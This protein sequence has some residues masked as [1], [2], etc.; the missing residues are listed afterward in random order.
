[1]TGQ[2]TQPSWFQLLIFGLK[3]GLLS[4]GGPVGQIALLRKELVEQKR[5]MS[6]AEFD[7]GLDFC[8]LLPGPE[9]QQLASFCG[10]KIGRGLVGGLIIGTTFILPG[11]LIMFLL[12][13]LRATNGDVAWIKAGFLG[14]AAAVVAIVIAALYRLVRQRLTKPIPI[15]LGIVGL[16]FTLGGW[17]GFA[18]LVITAGL[19][20]AF[21]LR[22]KLVPAIAIP[23]PKFQRIVAGIGFL[24]LSVASMVGLA[25]FLG[26]V[27]PFWPIGRFFFETG[28]VT[29]GGA[30]AILPHVAQVAVEKFQWLDAKTMVDG[31]ALAETTPGPLILVL[32]YVGFFAGWNAAVAGVTSLSPLAAAALAS[33]VVTF[34]TF[35][36]SFFF[37]L[38]LAPMVDQWAKH[39]I[40]AGILAGIG[41]L[42]TGSIAALAFILIKTTWV[43]DNIPQWPVIAISLVLLIFEIWKKPNAFYPAGLGLAAG[44]LLLG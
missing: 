29:F 30:Y 44:L 31:L 13:W 9:A 10:W 15:L 20:G 32:Q 17:L 43:Y 22:P 6:S 5:W 41:A 40:A 8:M 39:P 18:P 36:A 28:M 16:V 11:A 1:M 4:F 33:L 34:V 37:I 12:S 35:A 7:R 25:I 24:A 27:D 23:K 2:T 21:F 19:V 38:T 3:I 26:G 42:V 14:L